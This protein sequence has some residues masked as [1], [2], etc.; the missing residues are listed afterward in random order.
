VRRDKFGRKRNPND[1]CDAAL[2]AFR[3][4]QHHRYTEREIEPEY[5]TTEYWEKQER[6]MEQALLDMIDGGEHG[7]H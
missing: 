2:Y 1:C 3:E 7:Y 4:A 6:E 5:G